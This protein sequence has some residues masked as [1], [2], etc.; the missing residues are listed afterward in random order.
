MD[1]W[2]LGDAFCG[3]EIGYR[4]PPGERVHRTNGF[5]TIKLLA[6]SFAFVLTK[7]CLY[8]NRRYDLVQPDSVG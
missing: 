8:N 1:G 7:R 4:T 3:G 5:G 6:A 2:Q